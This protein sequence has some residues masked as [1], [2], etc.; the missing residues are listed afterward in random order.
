MSEQYAENAKKSAAPGLPSEEEIARAI[1]PLAWAECDAAG[2]DDTSLGKGATIG[3]LSARASSLIE[4]ASVSAL[5]RPAF[6]AERGAKIEAMQYAQDI[7]WQNGKLEAKLAQAVEDERGDIRDVL[8]A[9]ERG[10]ADSRLPGFAHIGD[11]RE[12]LGKLWALR[13]TQRARSASAAARGETPD[14]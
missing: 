9:C 13:D 12:G 11:L 5:I 10:A 14:A 3:A 1:A 8:D 7:A 4:A 6:D 2:V